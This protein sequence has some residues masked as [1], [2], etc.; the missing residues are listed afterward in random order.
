MKRLLLIIGFLAIAEI[1]IAQD[2]KVV[3]DVTSPDEKIHQAAM[4]HVKSMA[5]AYP[6]AQFELVVYSG[7]LDM[8][9]KEK[10][11]VK[12]EIKEALSNGNVTINVCKMTLARYQLDQSAL[13]DGVGTVPDG[14]L[15]I[16]QKQAE[17]WG[18]IKEA[19]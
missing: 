18:Y 17:G 3:F 19:N 6:D 15:E 12:E 1:G 7:A 14:I 11:S 2:F 5:K 10:S 16:L 13:I 4:R 8:L 9:L